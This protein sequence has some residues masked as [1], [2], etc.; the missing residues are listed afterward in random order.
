MKVI[1]AGDKFGLLSVVSRN[2]V[3]KNRRV[4]WK[5]VCDCGNEIDVP[6]RYLQRGTRTDCGCK[7]FE[8]NAKRGLKLRKDE[9]SQ[10]ISKVY[11]SYIQNAKRKQLSMNI[12]LSIFKEIIN[13]NC[14]YCGSPP[15]SIKRLRNV[16][17]RWNGIDRLNNSIGYDIQNCVPCCK[18]C[19][20]LKNNRNFSDF[21]IKIKTIHD[22]LFGEKNE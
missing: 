9:L 22:I 2:G 13:N 10:L 3:D 12:P 15:Q 7:D 19:N 18:D 6:T 21:K 4:L 17:L 1:I 14:F 5:C 20:Y 8:R 16:E 11:D